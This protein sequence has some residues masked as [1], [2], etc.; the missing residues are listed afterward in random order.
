M[1]DIIKYL[2]KYDGM[3]YTKYNF[4]VPVIDKNEPFWVSNSELPEFSYIYE[5]GSTCVGLINIVRRHLSLEIPGII[6]NKKTHEYPGGTDHGL[7]I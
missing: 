6:N 3:K 1:N 7:N 5:S 4:E 2:K